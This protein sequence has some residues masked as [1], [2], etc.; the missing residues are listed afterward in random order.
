MKIVNLKN[1]ENKEVTREPLFTG[2]IVQTQFM[3]EEEFGTNKVQIINVKFAPGARNKFHTHTNKQVLYVIEGEGIIADR[4]QEHK[5]VPGMAVIIPAGEEHWHG[6]AKK[7]SFAHLS[8]MG[9][10]QE[11]KI[12]E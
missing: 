6:A 11:M 3:L 4:K 7:S 5:L 1:I 9:Q 10:P 2:G 8:I 12:T